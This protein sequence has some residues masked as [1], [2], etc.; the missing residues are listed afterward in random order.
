MA[1]TTW[2][3]RP[4]LIV[5]ALGCL[6][7]AACSKP[8][9]DPLVLDGPQ[10]QISN[11]TADEWRDVEIWLN[12]YFRATVHSIPAH[13]RYRVPLSSFVS[14]YAQKFD[15]GRMQITALRLTAKHADGTPVELNKQFEDSG[16]A[17]ALGGKR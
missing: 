6:A 7:F 13:S 14:G 2:L 4:T 1:I 10:L 12:R 9:I 11:E 17:G 3:A 15:F 5:A 16:L 8:Q